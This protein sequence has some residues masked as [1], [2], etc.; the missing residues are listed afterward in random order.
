[1]WAYLSVKRES[2]VYC[3][4][5]SDET[6]K[7]LTMREQSKTGYVN[8]STRAVGDHSL[9]LVAVRFSKETP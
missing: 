2:A 7:N 9:Y 6:S 4:K 3:Q 8:N 5:G 1:M